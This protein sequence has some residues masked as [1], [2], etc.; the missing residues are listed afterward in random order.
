MTI[1]LTERPPETDQ[2]VVPEATGSGGAADRGDPRV[3]R[4]GEGG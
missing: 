3:E 4:F 2:E 1:E